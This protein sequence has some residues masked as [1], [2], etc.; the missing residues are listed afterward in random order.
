[1]HPA[2]YVALGVYALQLALNFA[3]NPVFFALRAFDAALIIM[4]ALLV[5]VAGMAWL[6][7]R[8][9]W[10]AAALT[11]PYLLWLLYAASLNVAWA[12]RGA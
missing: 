5:V 10:L 6:F 11:V 2:V 9:D 3:W 1:M 7:W 4:A 8:L 12:W